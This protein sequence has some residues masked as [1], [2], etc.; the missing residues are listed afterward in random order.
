MFLTHLRL[1]STQWKGISLLSTSRLPSW[2]AS[3]GE[4]MQLV[5]GDVNCVFDAPICSPLL[6]FCISCY[7]S[8]RTTGCKAQTNNSWWALKDLPRHRS[9]SRLFLTLPRAEDPSHACSVWFSKCKTHAYQAR[10]FS[11]CV[12]NVPAANQ[13]SYSQDQSSLYRSRAA[14][15]FV[16]ILPDVSI[17][18]TRHI[19]TTY[20][21][22]NVPSFQVA[23]CHHGAT[24][25]GL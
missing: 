17:I 1:L 19:F 22:R 13:H 25:N 15:F 10:S 23:A 9:S 4:E 20:V 16:S 12:Q 2:N 18:F 6:T 8:P 5:G 24:M 14:V 21:Q 7:A 11:G 3:K